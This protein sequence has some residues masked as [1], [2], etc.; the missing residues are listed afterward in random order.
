MYLQL[1]NYHMANETLYVLDAA[2]KYS[3]GIVSKLSLQK[4]LYLSGA[5]SPIK[6]V[7]LTFLK[8]SYH[9]RGP[10]SKDIQNTIDHV[11]ASGL[12]DI[13]GFTK[14]ENGKA[15]FVNYK[16]TEGGT[17]AVRL[18]QRYSHEAEKHW[19]ISI[20]YQLSK[21]YMQ[22]EKLE[23]DADHRIMSLV[24][25]EPSFKSL[26]KS[27]KKGYLINFNKK[28]EIT[29]QLISFLKNYSTHNVPLFFN[30]NKRKQAEIVLITFFEYLYLNYVNEYYHE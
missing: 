16:I 26:R 23:G 14:S 3:D 19:W 4:M 17:E 5:L 28:E 8:Y 2:E 30:G 18:L 29:S 12:V 6:E 21:I 7:I 20:I 13:C 1:K 25:Q 10:Y 15:A 22:S 27:N 24:Y 9:F 11:V